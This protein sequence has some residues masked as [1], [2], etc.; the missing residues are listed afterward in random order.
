MPKASRRVNTTFD[1]ET[2]S[3][4]RKAAAEDGVK[5]GTKAK[6]LVREGLRRDG[7]LLIE[8]ARTE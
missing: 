6:V 8:K 7:Y 4:L 3:A 1:K 2:L 5:P